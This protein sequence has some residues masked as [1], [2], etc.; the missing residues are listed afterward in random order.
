[1]TMLDDDNL[2]D[3][4]NPETDDDEMEGLFYVNDPSNNN[5]ANFPYIDNK[6]WGYNDLLNRKN[7]LCQ[8]LNTSCSGNPTS[9]T[10]MKNLSFIPLPVA[11]H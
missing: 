7:K 3:V 5:D 10:M 9:I 4:F 6:K 8:F 1:M 2:I 11:S